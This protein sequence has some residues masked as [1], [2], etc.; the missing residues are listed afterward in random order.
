[1]SPTRSLPLLLLL[2]LCCPTLASAT[3][4]QGL[5]LGGGLTAGR[6]NAEVE[7][8]ASDTQDTGLGAHLQLGYGFNQVVALTLGIE[9]SS[10]SGSAGDSFA[11]QSY[12]LLGGELGLRL[13]LHTPRLTPYGEVGLGVVS[14]GEYDK[15]HEDNRIRGRG[16]YLGAGLLVSLGPQVALDLGLRGTFGSLTEVEI[17]RVTLDIE[18]LDSTFSYVRFRGGIVLTF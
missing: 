12:R 3:S 18:N 6:L 17:G 14:L 15:A 9:G 1:M 4:T 7:G 16:G 8:I 2:L 13:H 10:L 11:T 5:M